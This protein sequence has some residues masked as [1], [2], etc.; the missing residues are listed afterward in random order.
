MELEKLFLRSKLG[1]QT[2]CHVGC[3]PALVR[4]GSLLSKICRIYSHISTHVYTALI[5]SL[6]V[7]VLPYLSYLGC[8]D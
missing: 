1:M 4:I 3:G 8:M 2:P 6:D 5:F 7:S